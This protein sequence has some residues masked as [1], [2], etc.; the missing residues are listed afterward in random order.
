MA[1]IGEGPKPTRMEL[2]MLR[3]R[4]ALAKR[5]H[6]LLEEKRDALISQFFEYVKLR[7]KIR[8]DVERNLKRI[9]EKYKESK[10]LLG[11]DIKSVVA[12]V[13]EISNIKLTTQTV[14][15]LRVPKIERWEWEPKYALYASTASFDEMLEIMKDT[16]EY[17]MKLIEVEH[18]LV[19][20]SEEIKRTRR[21]VNALKYMVI[22][23]LQKSI[24]WITLVL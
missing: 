24:K 13:P 22:P 18:S 20:L 17:L 15:G 19:E 4:L 11:R 1:K 7:D 3:K 9:Y 5:G 6:E 14:M 16:Q 10:A 21:R 12:T 2:L 8:K 23:R